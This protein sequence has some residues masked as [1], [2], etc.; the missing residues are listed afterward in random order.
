[1]TWTVRI[2]SMAST[3][4]VD[5]SRRRPVSTSY[6]RLHRQF[7]FLIERDL[8]AAI[9]CNVIFIEVADFDPRRA[10]SVNCRAF[11]ARVTDCHDG[12]TRMA[13]AG[14]LGARIT[15]RLHGIE[16]AGTHPLDLGL[17]LDQI[18]ELRFGRLGRLPQPTFPFHIGFVA[19]NRH[20][21]RTCA[22]SR[23]GAAYPT[24]W[25]R[26]VRAVHG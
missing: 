21:D 12:D 4:M 3:D 17:G 18:D 13:I 11:P 22:R 25:C 14:G 9:R 20:R 2:T 23:S 16:H 26:K 24:P 10:G 6:F 15:V 8:A 5:H 1:M 19:S 7:P